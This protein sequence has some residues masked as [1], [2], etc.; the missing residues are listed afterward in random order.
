[1][2]ICGT[3]A[4][5]NG[6]QQAKLL[7][8]SPTVVSPFPMSVHLLLGLWLLGDLDLE[9]TISFRD[10][11]WGSS[12]PRAQ[13]KVVENLSLP[14]GC[15]ICFPGPTHSSSHFKCLLGSETLPGKTVSPAG[16]M[17]EGWTSFSQ[18]TSVPKVKYSTP[19]PVK[20]NRSSGGTTAC[21]PPP[22]IWDTACTQCSC[23]HAHLGPVCGPA[24]ASGQL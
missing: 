24:F 20:V 8:G 1:M 16:G 10:H 3:G 18:R 6:N 21:H 13:P 5:W 2:K 9:L 4:A 17:V 23:L 22:K 15:T 14:V 7:W 19:Y 11:A 12:V